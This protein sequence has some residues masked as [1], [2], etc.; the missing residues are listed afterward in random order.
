MTDTPPPRPKAL[1]PGVFP[2]ERIEIDEFHLRRYTRED[3]EPLHE[4]IKAS[5]AELHPWMPWCVDPVKIEEQRD[6]IERGFLAWATGRAFDYGIGTSGDGERGEEFVGSISLMDRIGPGGLEIG[7]W[8]RSD[9]T[10]KGIMSRAAARLT[11]IALGLPGIER[12]EIH[13]DAANARSAAVPERL[14]YRLAAMV[15]RLEP[16]APGETGRGMVWTTP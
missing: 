15:E 9:A 1:P 7:Y 16:T 3:A 13:C 8:L 11:E 2:P 12:V 10:G 14:G 4:A 6:F 5:F